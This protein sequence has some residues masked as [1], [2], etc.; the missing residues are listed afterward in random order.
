MSREELGAA[1]LPSISVA[2]TKVRQAFA[3]QLVEEGDRVFE[4]G[5]FDR[6][7]ASLVGVVAYR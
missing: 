2:A 6:Q 5:Q 1:A 7:Q 4:S 3:Y